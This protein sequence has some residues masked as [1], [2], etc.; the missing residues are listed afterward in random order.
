MRAQFER[1]PF[2]P[3]T[4][5]LPAIMSLLWILPRATKHPVDAYVAQTAITTPWQPTVYHY[6]PYD[7]VT[8]HGA[9][10][11][12]IL[13]FNACDSHHPPYMTSELSASTYVCAAGQ[14]PQ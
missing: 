10:I 3:P 7:P 11:A 5:I 1:S 12:S 8:P 14:H 9:H 13:T 4:C 6:A 2:G